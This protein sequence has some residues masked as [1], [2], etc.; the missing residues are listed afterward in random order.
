VTDP[1]V[2]LIEVARIA[3]VAPSAVR[4]SSRWTGPGDGSD[5][6]SARRRS[7]GSPAP[8]GGA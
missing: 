7:R 8:G 5:S 3:G 1:I 4:F 6:A 2:A